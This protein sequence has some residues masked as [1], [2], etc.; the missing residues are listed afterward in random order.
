VSILEDT[1]I[2]SPCL[3]VVPVDN[4]LPPFCQLA[5][6]ACLV[7]FHFRES[8]LE[9]F[10][11]RSSPL[12]HVGVTAVVDV[13][14]HDPQR[15]LCL[16]P[17]YLERPELSLKLFDRFGCFCHRCASKKPWPARRRWCHR[18]GWPCGRGRGRGGMRRWRVC[19]RRSFG[20]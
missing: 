9:L 5:R 10:D 19:R 2:P 15:K 13:F 8:D 16:P 7:G 14:S 4:L 18:S 3:F 17:P 6:Q 12:P 1:V 20:N 11:L